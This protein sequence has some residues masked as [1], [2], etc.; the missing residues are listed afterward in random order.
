[1]RQYILNIIAFLCLCHTIPTKAQETIPDTLAARMWQQVSEFPQ[2]KLYTQT[3]RAEYVC[4]DTIWMRHHVVDALTGMPSQ[5]SRYVYVEL[6]NPFGKPVRRYMMRQDDNGIIY[7][8]AVT[9][10]D[11]PSGQYTLRAY[12]KYMINTTP[13]YLFQRQLWLRN[14]MESSVKITSKL[15]NGTLHISFVAP[16]TGKAIHSEIKVTS[17]D[18][19]IAFTGNSERGINIHALDI[20]SKRHCILVQIGNYGEYVPLTHAQIDLQIM[21]E[22]G[23][24]V[25]GQRCRMAYKAVENTGRG[26]DMTAVVTDEKERVVGTSSTSHRGMGM[27]SFEPQPGHSYRLTCTAADGRTAVRTLPKAMT[28]IPTLSVVQ[29]SSKITVRIVEPDAMLPKADRWLIVHQG[30]AP[31]YAKQTKST[32]VSFPR[33]LFHDGIVNF[34]LANDKMK[35]ISERIAFVWNERRNENI[36]PKAINLVAN[37]NLH[38]A[39]VDLS[40]S[41]TASCAVSITDADETT[42][43]TIQNIVSALLL[44]QELRGYVEAPAWYFAKP[45]RA[46]KLDLLMM[47]QGWRR[48]DIHK[49]LVGDIH[50]TTSKPETSM[51][52]SGKVTSDVSPHGLKSAS[53]TIS[54]NKGG[55]IDATTTDNKGMFRFNGFE[56]PDSTGYMLMA[57][58]HKGST[59]VVLWMDDTAYPNIRQSIPQEFAMPYSPNFV[60]LKRASDRIAINQGVRTIFLPEVTV[61]TQRRPKTEFEVLTKINGMSITAEML[62]KEN[63]K[64]VFDYLIS[65]P[66][67]L[68][69]DDSGKWFKYR[70]K[71]SYLI[72]NGALWNG[73]ENYSKGIISIDTHTPMVTALQNIN[74]K[75]VAQI[76]IIKGAVAGTLPGITATPN[77]LAMENS[78]IIIT[79]KDDNFTAKKNVVLIRPLGYQQPAAF[80]NPQYDAPGDYAMR[81]TVYWNPSVLVKAGKASMQFLPN[82]AKRYRITIEGVDRSGKLIS[83]QKETE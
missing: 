70:G 25:M 64:S 44:T 75:D 15:N 32:T 82:G 77:S 24:L 5:A 36:E 20:G 17:E 33:S 78:A 2:E 56:L 9:S 40:D 10:P 34:L 4:G 51:C 57:R 55:Y 29:N 46:G 52:I 38:T 39:T 18:G 54:A 61:E 3:D 37:G 11:M 26:I 72:F 62:K 35:I 76:D 63:N 68:I 66:T 49:T 69:Y 81:Q 22:G 74:I 58:S 13:D 59:N 14:V 6:L 28:D 30:G 45:G 23:H 83:V 73:D 79:T 42:A 80:Y 12:T 19:D 60:T 71:S 31:L 27:V 7:G 47:T 21:P 67:G 65:A 1:M 16:K 8:C 48:Y 43:D 53:V 41:T 50:T